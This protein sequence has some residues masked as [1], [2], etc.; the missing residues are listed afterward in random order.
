M[1]RSPLEEALR[2]AVR[3]EVRCDPTMR[4]IYATDASHYQMV[5]QA[6]V[7]PL[8]EADVVATVRVARERGVPITSRGG[9]TS[10]A[11]QTFGSGIVIDFSKH[12][13]KVLEVNETERW[14]RVEPGI[15]RDHLNGSLRE[16]KLHFAPDPATSSRATVG[17]MIANNSSG[18]RSIVYGK[19]V[20]H[21]LAVR[22]LLSDGSIVELGARDAATWAAAAGDPSRAGELYRGV[23]RIVET[24]RD[25]IRARYPKVM[26]RV[27]GYNLDE[28]LDPAE[29]NLAKLVC[30]SEGSLGIILDATVR[31]TPLPGAT[32][33]CI[34]HFDDAVEAVRHVPAM[35]EHAPSTIELLDDSIIPE[36]R[37]NPSTR[38]FADF[39][40]G[41]PAAIDIVEF[42]ADTQAEA[43]ER[44]IAFAADMRRRGIGYAHVLRHDPRAISNVW[45]LRR[46]AF[47]L[48]SNV[49]GPRRP[50]DF[51]DDACV[52][53]EHLADYV[54]K[55]KA[56]CARHG[57]ECPIGAHASVGVL[58]PKPMLD[59][60]DPEDVKRM[61][62]IAWE[63]FELVREYGGS[64]AG[65]HGD[66]LVR[67]EFIR[68]F[69]G[70]RLYEAFREVKGLFDPPN[71]MNPGKIVDTPGM[72][73]NLRHHPPEAPDYAVRVAEVT[74]HYHYRD[75]N[76]F[77][78]AVEQCTGV[79][80]CRK[81]GSGTMCPSYMATKDEEDS[82][83][84][85]ANAL[86]LAMSG[87][88]EQDGGLTGEGVMD[89]LSL[90]LQ[91][92]SCKAE[93]P[94]AVDMAKLKSDVLQMRHDKYGV[95]LGYRLMGDS[96]R[97]ARLVAGPL[98]PI[99]NW[100]QS[101][102]PF[103]RVLERVAGID[104]RR[105]IPMFASRTLRAR[106]R[107]RGRNGDARTRPAAPPLGRVV[108]FAD[109][110][111]SY[112]ET[113][114]GVAAVELLEACGYDVV[115][116]NAGCCQRPRLS[117]GMV[118]AAKKD[119]ERT[120][121][122]L[123]PYAEEGLP[124]LC[125]E[126]SCC[127]SLADDLPDLI[128]DAEMGAKVASRVQML[129]AFL[130]A[131]L[132]A[133]RLDGV[134][135]SPVHANILLHGHCHQKSVLEGGTE[136]MKRLFAAV[137]GLIATEVD[138]GCCG[139]AGSFGYEH[140]DVSMKV[141]EQRL[142]PAIRAAMQTPD[143]AVCANGFSCRHQVKDACGVTAKHWVE[144]VRAEPAPVAPA[145]SP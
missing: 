4:G 144:L 31:L 81:I 123:L 44:A 61:R 77:A 133:G 136:G 16:R 41:E 6:V 129:D 2:S 93:C 63:A 88:L 26:R 15:V 7:I 40:E 55:L 35:L 86:R 43:D 90:C 75:Q 138:A 130:A 69:F 14:A 142:F 13:C 100:F 94:N 9:G 114:I 122:N 120:L 107:A 84:G 48:Q 143:T 53:V 28:L 66:G 18:T 51:V 132:D 71:L 131:E 126:P 141:G 58:H 102:S 46:L 91:C 11:G 79:G 52:P 108:L 127:S 45:E 32:A 38:L 70:D 137:P 27:G 82:T 34:V 3:G 42:M 50:L 103:K 118:R 67:G 62:A 39:F 10:L 20:D 64:W 99:V 96:P 80:A 139:M 104:S 21:L 117:K 87:Q 56:I 54:V 23:E 73:E 97:A 145:A 134:R 89:A 47:G 8:D 85:R 57:V 36:S 12:L 74:S 112:Y 113:G 24:N 78:G 124:I 25:E 65:E 111:A 30:G 1:S 5:P 116:P 17:G 33:L 19:T 60:H 105:P 83:R 49:K 37:R 119:G 128:D 95:P 72:V 110:Y 140:H 106:L 98:A 109:T 125:L 121:R 59:L 29:R 76:G 92:K 115:L 22:L 101:L 68:P 135:F